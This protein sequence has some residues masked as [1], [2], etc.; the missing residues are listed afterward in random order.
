MSRLEAARSWLRRKGIVAAAVALG[1]GALAAPAVA[2]AAPPSAAG[3][4]PRATV[5][6]DSGLAR[7]PYMGF[8]TYFP[9]WAK[10][11]ENTIVSQADAMVGRGLRD[12]GYSYVWIDAGWWFGSRDAHGTITVPRSRW[13]H[14]M[15][16]LTDYIHA[17]GLRAGIYTD[18]GRNGCGGPHRGSYGHYQKDA[19]LFA[20]WG[21][22]ALKVDFCGGLQ[23][24]L[25]PRLA[26]GDFSQALRHN[27]SGRP[28]L[29]S[30]CDPFPP[31]GPTI[32]NSWRTH[33]DIG[34][35]GSVSFTS[36]LG[37]LNANAAHPG[38]A[39]P[40]HWNDPDYL[41]PE[42]GM[43]T[44]EFRAQFTMWSELAAPLMLGTDLATMSAMTAT[45]VTNPE[46][47]AIDQDP[48]GVQGMRIAQQEAA[49]IW[50]R[51]LANGDTAVA[52]LNPSDQPVSVTTAATAL[53]LPA[54]PM[55]H[56][57]D[58]W[59]HQTNDTTGSVTATVE[60]HDVV[61]DRVGLGA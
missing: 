36:M 14:G 46:V 22:D 33:S 60:P 7:T 15:R 13:P 49:E 42:Q 19:N 50:A 25:T 34:V 11:N 18:A 31:F 2:A 55:Y 1:A 39:G 9:F 17:R 28:I 41:V 26:Y 29:L 56:V 32:G 59:A 3:S 54:S 12:A 38:A 30:T 6:V 51:P 43:S 57:R 24:G 45:I 37:N 35:P 61:M 16:W 21:F 5:S 47:I 10:Y 4:S 40:G 27:S 8:S 52:I 44:S 48:A 53:G 20:R 23:M 58:V